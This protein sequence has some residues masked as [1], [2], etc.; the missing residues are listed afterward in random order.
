MA[1]PRV[2]V[3]SFAFVSITLVCMRSVTLGFTRRQDQQLALRYVKALAATCMYVL[4]SGLG[5]DCD[6]VLS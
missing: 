4:L 5:L 3:H 1:C 2:H 6:T